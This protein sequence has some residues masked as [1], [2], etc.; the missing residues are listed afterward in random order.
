MSNGVATMQ[1]GRCGNY[2]VRCGHCRRV[3]QKHENAICY[4]SGLMHFCS[5]I[6]F[7]LYAG[8]STRELLEAREGAKERR[9][10][11]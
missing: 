4:D 11:S 5:F 10:V 3:P 2:A 8:P 9:R 7:R 1:C 6:C